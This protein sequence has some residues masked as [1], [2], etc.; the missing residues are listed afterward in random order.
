MTLQQATE[1]VASHG[2]SDELDADELRAAFTA[3]YEREPDADDE[4]V[5]LWSLCCAA[6]DD[7]TLVCG[8]QV[9]YDNSGVGHNWRDIAADDINA[10]VR[11]AIAAEIIDGKITE[12]DDWTGPDGQHYRWTEA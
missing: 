2:D 9:Q 1:W 11:E 12:C 4:H 5:G 3:I 8:C 10:D 6:F 7:D